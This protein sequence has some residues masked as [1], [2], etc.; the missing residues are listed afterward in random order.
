[1]L[2]TETGPL[3]EGCARILFSE[4]AFRKCVKSKKDEYRSDTEKLLIL[5]ADSEF[6]GTLRRGEVS[7]RQ[8]DSSGKS[9]PRPIPTSKYGGESV[10]CKRAL[11]LW[12]QGSLKV[13]VAL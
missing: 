5:C 12:P 6:M 4:Y 3:P 8:G 2:S 11:Q 10:F 7:L 1:M 13:G 9:H